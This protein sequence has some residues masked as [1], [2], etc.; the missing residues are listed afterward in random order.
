MTH[1]RWPSPPILHRGWDLGAVFRDSGGLCVCME[2]LGVGAEGQLSGQEDQVASCHRVAGLVGRTSPLPC[3]WPPPSWPAK[4]HETSGLWEAGSESPPSPYLAPLQGTGVLLL[5][6]QVQ[7]CPVS[8]LVPCLV[9]CI[10]L[11][12][13][14]CSLR[15]SLRELVFICDIKIAQSFGNSGY[16]YNSFWLLDRT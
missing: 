1:P 2:A 3:P 7:C 9:P 13:N 11:T 5:P 12:V 15:Y 6:L 8:S 10:M 14:Q 16:F 4:G